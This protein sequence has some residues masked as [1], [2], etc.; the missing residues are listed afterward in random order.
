[1]PFSKKIVFGLVSAALLIIILEMVV[2]IVDPAPSFHIHGMEISTD[3]IQNHRLRELVRLYRNEPEILKEMT[4]VY[5]FIQNPSNLD[6]CLKPG[7]NE[8]IVN[9]MNPVDRVMKKPF[10][11]NSNSE[12]FR[13]PCLVPHDSLVLCLGD[14]S[15]YG[16]G[17]P[18]SMSY[19]ARLQAILG[20][21]FLV[22]NRGVPGYTVQN[23]KALINH[24]GIRPRYAIISFGANDSFPSHEP[25]KGTP[26]PLLFRGLE[27]LFSRVATYRWIKREVVYSS[28]RK[29]LELKPETRLVP[30]V[31]FEEINRELIT[32]LQSVGAHVSLLEICTP[33]PGYQDV[34]RR[35]SEEYSIPLVCFGQERSVSVK[36]SA[37]QEIELYLEERYGREILTLNPWLFDYADPGCHPGPGGSLFLAEEIAAWIESI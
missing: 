32:Q 35:L 34:I 11:F 23:G 20:P 30:P 21:S 7:L 5:R 14:S 22:I 33:N 19:P 16:W 12:G 29:Q 9:F 15:T 3:S 17:L 37:D 26:D 10:P 2:R 13:G 6:Y 4:R 18:E 25:Q 1:M 8:S 27:R 24:S 31:R 36:L 28:F